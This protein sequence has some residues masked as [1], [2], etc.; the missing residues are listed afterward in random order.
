MTTYKKIVLAGGSGQMGT[1]I[2]KYFKNFC[3]DIVIFSRRARAPEGNIR[4]VTWDAKTIGNWK[5][6]LE[7]I[8]LLI[9]LTGKSVNCRYTKGNKKEII[10]SRINSVNVLAEALNSCRV[11]PKLWIQC[12][13]ATIY[14]HAE[15]RPMTEDS[16]EIGEGF[17]IE[18]CKSWEGAFNNL[19]FER[20]EMRKVILRTSLVLGKEEGVFPRLKN[21]VRFGLGGKQGSGRQMVSWVHE[22]DVVKMVEWIANHETINGVVNCT[23]PFPIDN[24]EFMRIF[25]KVCT[26]PIGLPAPTWL[27]EIGALF[28]GTETELILKSRWVLPEKIES[29]GYQ[30]SFPDLESALTEILNQ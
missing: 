4:T 8:D 9:N 2:A 20:G 7:G 10:S 5:T 12:A 25:R 1:A 22:I 29:S 18:V 28:I 3:K 15:D 23:T 6:E 21:L 16:G 30:F 14:R 24:K 19:S 27:L 26:M 13:S 11:L 17:S